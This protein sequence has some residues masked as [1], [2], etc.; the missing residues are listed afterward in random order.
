[1]PAPDAAGGSTLAHRPYGM[2][3]Q[4]PCCYEPA[5]R[6][7][8]EARPMALSRYQAEAASPYALR[9][10]PYAQASAHRCMWPMAMAPWLYL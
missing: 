8:A 9:P 7:E 6:Y 3:Y 10:T 5:C 4:P 1:M 2:P